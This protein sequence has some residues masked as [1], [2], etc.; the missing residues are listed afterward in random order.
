MQEKA[1]EPKDYRRIALAIGVPAATGLLLVYI[2]VNLLLV[3][4]F[5]A[6]SGN[7]A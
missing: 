4:K 2:C 1:P 6:A 5:L 7:A 3:L